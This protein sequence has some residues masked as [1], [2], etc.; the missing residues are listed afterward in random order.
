[1]ICDIFRQIKLK[2]TIHKGMISDI[3]HQIK[4]KFAT[5][6]I[7]I[8]TSYQPKLQVILTKTQARRNVS[9]SCGDSDNFFQQ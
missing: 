6:V 5:H 7:I 1:M 4:L 2:F 8:K 9:K 3:F